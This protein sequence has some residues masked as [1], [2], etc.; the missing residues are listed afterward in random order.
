MYD[1]SQ[2]RGTDLSRGTWKVTNLVSDLED[3]DILFG[4]DLL[5]QTVRTVDGPAQ[6]FSLEF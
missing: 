6:M 4:L 1:L 2:P 5:H 3:V